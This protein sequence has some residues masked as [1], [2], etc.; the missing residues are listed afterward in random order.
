[1]R[2]NY[3]KGGTDYGYIMEL[4]QGCINNKC[5]GDDVVIYPV[6]KNKVTKMNISSSSYI[7][8]NN[9]FNGKTITAEQLEI[10]TRIGLQNQLQMNQLVQ[11]PADPSITLGAQSGVIGG[12]PTSNLLL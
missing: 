11:S 5:I 3:Q 10:E 9:P 12:L 2:I 4:E 1:M 7:D 8:P 6:S